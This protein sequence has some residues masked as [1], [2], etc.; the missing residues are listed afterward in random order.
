ME[1]PQNRWNIWKLIY[2]ILIISVFIGCRNYSNQSN[3]DAK[4]FCDKKGKHY[5]KVSGSD[6]HFKDK[7]YAVGSMMI[8]SRIGF[9]EIRGKNIEF[10]VTSFWDGEE[11]ISST[12]QEIL[13]ITGEI[14]KRKI[15][16]NRP[17]DVTMYEKSCKK[18]VFENLHFKDF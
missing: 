16:I 7:L 8:D 3:L 5:L 4:C 2:C 17:F 6:F 1:Q 14:G 11:L 10:K 9:V 18:E 15:I 13:D 12:R